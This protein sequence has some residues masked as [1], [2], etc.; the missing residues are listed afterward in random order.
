MLRT[1][2]GIHHSVSSKEAKELIIQNRM[3]K[4][5]EYER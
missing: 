3:I 4:Y 2:R 5:R 1:L